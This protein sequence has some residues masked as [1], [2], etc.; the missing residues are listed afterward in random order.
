[1]SKFIKGLLL[2]IGI[3][4]PILGLTTCIGAKSDEQIMVSMSSYGIGISGL[5]I[6]LVWAITSWITQQKRNDI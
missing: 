3:L 4:G 2:W 1:M 5:I 6:R